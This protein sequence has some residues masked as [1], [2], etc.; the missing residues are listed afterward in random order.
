V[1]NGFVN[2]TRHK[3]DGAGA[4]RTASGGGHHHHGSI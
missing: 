2:E 1:V 3:A 4:V